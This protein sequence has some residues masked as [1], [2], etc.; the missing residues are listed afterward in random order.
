MLFDC[1][2]VIADSEEFW[3]DID[4]EMLRHFGVPDYRGEHKAHV[5]G[6]SFALSVGFYRDFF[7][8]QAPL[9]EMIRVRTEIGKDF[10]ANKIPTYA[11][12]AELL[13]DL[14][15]HGLKLA[16]ATSSVSDLILPFLHRHDIFNSFDAI[17]TGEMVR[18]GKPHPDI[19]LLA[20]SRVDV[21]ATEALVIE[22]ALAGLQ[23]GRAA[24]AKTIAV[25]DARWLDVAEF[26]GQSDYLVGTLKEVGPLVAKILER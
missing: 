25:P 19:Y 15:G 11:G 2:G 14:R 4:A 6:R 5:I 9:D 22:D 1:D 18:N 12:T 8:I 10:Y 17:I 7:K 20:A 3:N 16:M 23:A 26:E 24:G 13:R 21:P